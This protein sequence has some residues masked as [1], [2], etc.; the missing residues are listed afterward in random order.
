MIG[1]SE[2]DVDAG[3]NAGVKEALISLFGPAP[4]SFDFFKGP[5][6][7]RLIFSSLTPLSL[8]QARVSLPN[9]P[10]CLSLPLFMMSAWKVT[11]NFLQSR[12]QFFLL[13]GRSTS[14]RSFASACCW[15]I[16]LTASA[17]LAASPFRCCLILRF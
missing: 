10:P 16:F 8:N 11:Y 1:D 9:L 6:K 7:S 14:S 5:S 17:P 12:G 3:K 4:Q 15:V 13:P 2:R